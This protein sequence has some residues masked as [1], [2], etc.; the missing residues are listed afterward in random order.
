VWTLDNYRRLL[1]DADAWRLLV[2]SFVFVFGHTLVA[3]TLGTLLAWILER[4]NTPGRKLFSA[5][6]LVPLIIP[7]MLSTISWIFLLSPRIG[8]LNLWWHQ[9]TG[10]G[11][12]LNIYSFAGMS[13]DS[14]LH[15][16]P[17][18]FLIMAAA[19]RS[20][21]PSLEE[22][23]LVSRASMVRTSLKVTLPLV[24]P[25][26]LACT[27]IMAVRGLE[28]FETPALL[29][30]PARIHVFTTSIYH[31][32]AGF[33]P[34]YGL[35][36]AYASVLLVLSTLGVYLYNGATRQSSRFATITGKGFRPRV[37]DLGRCR[38]VTL[39]FVVVYVSA[40]VGLPLL[41]LFWSSFLPLYE[42]PSLTA[43]AK[44]SLDNYQRVLST[45]EIG[46]AVRNSL[47]LAVTSAT[48]VTFLTA[49]MAWVVV[50]SRIAGRW[51]L[52]NITFLPMSVPGIVMGLALIVTY[53][54]VPVPIYG[55]IWILLVA[56]T[57]RYIPYGMRSASAS[58]VQINSELEEAAAVCGAGWFQTFRRVLVPLL[59]PGLV[60][61]WIY[62]V[63]VSVRELSTSL[64]LYSPKAEVLSVLMFEYWNNS[65]LTTVAALGV[66]MVVALLLASF[67]AQHF[68][69]RYR[70]E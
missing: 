5:L 25:A 63:T 57:T 60:S 59:L 35:A 29:G 52:D 28:S 50:R 26:L 10:W 38:Y 24:R 42:V 47:F 46:R 23:A 56:Y 15:W 62:I 7:G 19:F 65:E 51:L 61:G 30:V 45:A 12:F 3:V 55:T 20:M 36:S 66:L 58:L 6:V 41:V 67:L 54:A 43:V 4:T 2:N 17:F 27:L 48:V 40:A 13:W 69:N 18:V 34:K 9:L 53:L 70:F 16:S 8:L 21:D 11:P 32:T 37:M 44:M 49:I 22:A 39:A 31:A 1:S 14:G 68:S 33:P 64:L